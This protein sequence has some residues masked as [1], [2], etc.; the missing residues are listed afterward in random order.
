MTWHN[1][2]VTL[3]C[4]FQTQWVSRGGS[5]TAVICC[6]EASGAFWTCFPTPAYTYKSTGGHGHSSC[7][8][9]NTQRMPRPVP[10]QSIGSAASSTAQQWARLSLPSYSQAGRW[11]NH[12]KRPC[13][14]DAGNPRVALWDLRENRPPSL[15]TLSPTLSLHLN[16]PP[17][18]CTCR[19]GS[20]LCLY[21][22]VS[23]QTC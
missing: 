3:S 8:F 21:R 5:N 13:Q 20:C 15:P 11:P 2:S 23:D 16:P 22:P 9:T 1:A 7:L 14:F 10:S 12:H 6:K 19:A 4:H 17:C 18:H